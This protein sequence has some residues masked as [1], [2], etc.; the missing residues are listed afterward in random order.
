M[1]YGVS[2][3][4][5]GLQYSVRN[6]YRGLLKVYEVFREFSCGFE[7]LRMVSGAFS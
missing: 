1:F 2:E 7:K 5:R 4:F 3:S 6:V